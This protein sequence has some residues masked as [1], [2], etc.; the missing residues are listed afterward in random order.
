VTFGCGIAIAAPN[1]GVLQTVFGSMPLSGMIGRIASGLKKIRSARDF[2]SRL[3]AGF[4]Y[5]KT[6]R[7]RAGSRVPSTQQMLIDTNWLGVLSNL[8]SAIEFCDCAAVNLAAF[9]GAFG[10][11]V[12][13]LCSISKTVS[14][15]LCHAHSDRNPPASDKGTRCANFSW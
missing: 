8:F 3:R 14:A 2:R 6:V 11:F 9:P 10:A 5:S 1:V 13:A 7:Q 12:A 15:P 4:E